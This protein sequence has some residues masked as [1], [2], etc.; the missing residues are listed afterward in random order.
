MATYA[1]GDVQGCWAALQRLLALIQFDETQDCLWFTGD[2]INRGPDSLAVLRFVRQLPHKV[3]V[4][5]NHDLHFLAVYYAGRAVVKGD[6]LDQLLA[7]PDCAE[8]AA[9][10]C[11][12]PLLHVDLQRNAAC[13]HAGIPPM[14]RL[15]QAQQYAR[16]LENVL[17]SPQRDEFFQHMYA[18]QPDAW[19]ES[20]SG[21]PRY[22]LITN[23]FTRMRFLTDEGKLN[24]SFKGELDSAPANLI[25]WYEIPRVEPLSIR[26]LFGHWAALMG[27]CPVP[28][29]HALDGGCVWG[30]QLIALRLEDERRFSVA[31]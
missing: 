27:Q 7:A 9:W 1:I 23:Y 12:Q 20:L 2:L 13:V 18:D 30:N 19:D 10:L 5:G 28:D 14:W 29:F 22:R 4:L 8:L 3:T 15:A 16:E 31:A 17:Q 11:Q 6:T 24:L 26:L 21:W 25:P